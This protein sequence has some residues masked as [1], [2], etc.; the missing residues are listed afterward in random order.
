[1]NILTSGVLIT[2]PLGDKMKEYKENEMTKGDIVLLFICFAL[3][4]GF[5]ALCDLIG[6]W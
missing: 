3:P 4:I 5:F 2:L 1:M 6:L